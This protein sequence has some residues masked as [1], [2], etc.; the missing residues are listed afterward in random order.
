MEKAS[1][2]R[3]LDNERGDKGH[4]ERVQMG[5]R[6]LGRVKLEGL[7]DVK[8][9]PSTIVL[10]SF[11]SINTLTF[12]FCFCVCLCRSAG[13]KTFNPFQRQKIRSKANLC[14]LMLYARL[15][16]CFNIQLKHEW[17][18]KLGSHQPKV[19][20]ALLPSSCRK[21]QGEGN[22]RGTDSWTDINVEQNVCKMSH[23]KQLG[24]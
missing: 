1:D 14:S 10:I 12:L 24:E 19:E 16:S 21:K 22:K 8:H 7:G 5:E 4:V 9:F 18:G 11:S 6:E 13:P 17:R 3:D 2:S 20:K 23:K 15:H